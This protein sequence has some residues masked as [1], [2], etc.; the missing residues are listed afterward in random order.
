MVYIKVMQG[1]TL[2]AAEA[3]SNPVYV[4]RQSKNNLIVRCSEQSA[5]G[6][7]SL[8]GSIIYQIDGKNSMELDSLYTAHFIYMTDYDAI[9]SELDNMDEEDANPEIPDDVSEDEIFTRAELTTR[10]KELEETNVML[11]ECLLE[12]SEAVYA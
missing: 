9:V 7:L 1:D 2:I 8:D 6:I 3:H 11:M 10:V 5:Q 4:C 12:M